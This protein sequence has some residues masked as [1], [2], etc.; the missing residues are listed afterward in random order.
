[1]N[2]HKALATAVQTARKMCS[3]PDGS[4]WPGV[5]DANKGSRAEA[6]AAVREWD[7][8]AAAARL[9]AARRKATTATPEPTQEPEP[10]PDA[11]EPISEEPWDP[12]PARFTDLEYARS[13]VL[14]RGPSFTS[15]HERY[16]VPIR[17]PDG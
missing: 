10:E 11:P 15:A 17:E 12:S 7:R 6:C 1:M 16:A 3:D 2:E 9:A 5:Q 8:Q 4:N 14:D 13:C